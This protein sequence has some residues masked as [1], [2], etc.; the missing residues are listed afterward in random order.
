MSR[1]DYGEDGQT[2]FSFQEA[3][4]TTFGGFNEALDVLV[5]GVVKKGCQRCNVMYCTSFVCTSFEM[6]YAVPWV[7]NDGMRIKPHCEA[8]FPAIIFFANGL[9]VILSLGQLNSLWVS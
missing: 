5:S 9:V 1:S 3:N 6:W 7:I 2:N 4:A 8:L